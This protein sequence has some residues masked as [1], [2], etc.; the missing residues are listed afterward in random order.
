MA[1]GLIFRRFVAPIPPVPEPF[2]GW[3]GHDGTWSGFPTPATRTIYP[4]NF[5]GAYDVA[6]TLDGTKAYVCGSASGTIARINEWTLSSPFD[7]SGTPTQTGALTPSGSGS[8]IINLHFS[9]DGFQLIFLDWA[10]SRMG[11]VTLSTP[12]SINTAGTPSYSS[13]ILASGDAG[14]TFITP[15][16]Q[17]LFVTNRN[18]VIRRYTMSE[19]DISTLSFVGSSTVGSSNWH[20][21]YFSGDGLT[22]FLG[23]R[24]TSFFIYSL[25]SAYDIS[26]ASNQQQITS[27]A[28][29]PI[30]VST[31]GLRFTNLGNNFFIGQGNSAAGAIHR[32]QT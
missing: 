7:F 15:D 18:S 28:G 3:N 19:G 1:E 25:S 9:P 13:G 21:I 6:F 20:G 30:E 31:Y 16:G 5:G 27:L 11:S 4:A 29:E 22:M 8:F 12:F 17:T 32:Y 24:S 2:E 10:N 26:T 23:I 14:S